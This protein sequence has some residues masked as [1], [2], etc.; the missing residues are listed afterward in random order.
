VLETHC[1]KL[2][3]YNFESE[4]DTNILGHIFEHSLND[5]E[6]VRAQ[7]EGTELDKSKTK[8]KKDGVFYTPK[9]ITKYI[10][11][12]TVGKLCEEKKAEIGIDEAEFARD[13]KGRKTD[14]LKKLDAQL[15]QYRDWLLQLTICDPACGSGAFLNQA[16]EFLMG[17]HRYVDELEAQLLGY[18]FEFPGVEAHILE[19]NIYGV[20]IN[21]ESVEIARLSLW[22]RTAKKGRKLTSLSSNIKCGNS[23][24]DDPAVAGPLAFNWQQE[25]AKVFEKGG[26]DVVIGNPPYVAKTFDEIFKSY[27][28]TNYQTA[29]YQLDLYVAFMEKAVV[30]LKKS[31]TVGFIVPNSWLKNLMFGSCRE[32]LARNLKFTIIIPNLDNVFEEA[33]VDTLVYVGVKGQSEKNT[34]EIGEFNH[35]SYSKKHS[36]QQERFLENDK[37][38]FNVEVDDQ[39]LEIFKKI[40]EK[41][42]RLADVC[43]ITRG[44]NPYDKYR[45]QSAEV[46]KNKLYHA[47][48]KKDDTFVPELRGKHINRYEYLWDDVS[49]VSYGEWLAAA[50]EPKYFEGER[51]LCRQILSSHLNC[52]LIKEPFIIDQSVFIAK[53]LDEY[54]SDYSS[55]YIL[56]LLASKLLVYYFK[57][58][59]NEFDALFPKIKIGEFRELP[60]AKIEF[61]EQIAISDKAE[62]LTKLTGDIA[63]VQASFLQLLQSQFDLPK[64]STKLQQWPS[65]DFKGFMA[66]LGKAKVVLSLDKQAEWMAYFTKKKTEANALQSEIDRIDKEIDKM[67]YGLYGLT[68][69]EIRV[70]E[71]V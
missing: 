4:V 24:I 41:S 37:F 66:E 11:D 26:F 16:L 43:D 47:D 51:I 67:V 38:I 48:F 22:L 6:N 5:I 34:I 17:E 63:A 52:C 39:S 60:I 46:I 55:N 32:F 54:K 3:T 19:H 30:V 12:N 23:L 70:V 62:T 31:G 15:K 36:V 8:R 40:D 50:R 68:E 29:Q 64:P 42:I 57:F 45:G 2:S 59:A 69:E 28:K 53:L 58:K 61:K 13:R 27:L 33:S 21:E 9:Y 20:D 49:Y 71:G 25:F 18:A 44:I 14:T 56:S 1:L 7:L 65:L 10:V 35:T